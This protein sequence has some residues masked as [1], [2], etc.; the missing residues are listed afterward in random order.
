MNCIVKD[1][2]SASLNDIFVGDLLNFANGS[3]LFSF[4]LN[5]QQYFIV[6]LITHTHSH[7]FVRHNQIFQGAF[8]WCGNRYD[9][10]FV[11]GFAAWYRLGV[12]VYFFFS[13]LCFGLGTYTT[14]LVCYA[15]SDRA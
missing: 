4:S 12:T 1:T 15:I 10:Y 5:D 8:V 14:T 2:V 9:I 11:K 3:V 6:L 13:A 7:S